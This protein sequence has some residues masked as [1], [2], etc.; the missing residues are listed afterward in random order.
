MEAFLLLLIMLVVT[1]GEKKMT[2]RVLGFDI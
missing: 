1:G 2:G